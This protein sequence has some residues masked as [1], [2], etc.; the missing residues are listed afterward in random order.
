MQKITSRQIVLLGIMYVINTT[1]L[2]V[3][4]QLITRAHQ[5]AF[6]CYLLSGALVLLMLF[7]LT[8][9]SL[10]FPGQDLFQSLTSRFPFIGKVIV[11][12]YIL[13]Y[14]MVLVRDIR[15]ISDFTN[16]VLLPI[17]PSLIIAL[18]IT[19][20]VIYIARGG[21]K[22]VLGITELYGPIIII[23]FA[24]MPII[25][26]RDFNFGLMRPL[27]HVNWEKTFE[28]SWISVA[29]LGQMII[30]PFIFS[31]KDYKFKY[32]FYS[33]LIAAGIL[34]GL[35]IMIILLLGVEVSGRMM[36]PTY[37]LVRQLRITDF[38]D[39]FDLIV[40]ALWFPGV[41]LNL[42]ISLYII[43]YGMKMILPSLSG[44]MMAAPIGLFAFSCA[45]WFYSSSIELFNFNKE[46][47]LIALFFILVLPL[48]IFAI[49]RP[50]KDP[51]RTGHLGNVRLEKAARK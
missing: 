1:M 20:T 6:I 19:A 28:G 15:I 2:N 5:H 13:F 35:V 10:R 38:L 21:A 48:L 43:C 46:W 47:T 33:M 11:V 9:S 40:V 34:A 8:R 51:K 18:C 30:L 36:Y 7:L 39:R 49:H 26:F 24:L 42:S 50:V 3:P 37:E 31:S 16:V 29:Y 32:G 22:T 27:L 44:K 12:L 45:L 14:F 4:S 17:T 25:V 41:L 23:V